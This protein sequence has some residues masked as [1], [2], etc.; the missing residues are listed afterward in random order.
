MRL[1]LE[2]G[3]SLREF[4]QR[5]ETLSELYRQLPACLF[6]RKFPKSNDGVSLDHVSAEVRK[7]LG[8]FTRPLYPTPT[9]NDV[10]SMSLDEASSSVSLLICPPSP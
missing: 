2:N 7:L 3:A 1:L 10:C 9:Q 6:R 5:D 4:L 8:R